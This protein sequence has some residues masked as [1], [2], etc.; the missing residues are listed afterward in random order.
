V[1]TKPTASRLGSH[2]ADAKTE[3]VRE[4]GHHHVRAT[5]SDRAPVSEPVDG[6]RPS[7]VPCGTPSVTGQIPL[8]DVTDPTGGTGIAAEPV[9][10]LVYLGRAR[11]RGEGVRVASWA[12]TVEAAGGRAVPIP[13]MIDHRP[14]LGF[15][16]RSL[17]DVAAGR[18]VPESMA[19]STR[20]VCERL[21]R[22]EPDLVVCMT[23]RAYHP[24]LLDGPWTTVL[25]HVD[26]LAVSYEGRSKIARSLPRRAT[27][28][29]LA[30][31]ARRFER[32]SATTAVRQVAAGWS[33]AA[34]LGAL[35]L[36]IGVT[37]RDPRPEPAGSDAVDVCFVGTLSYPPNVE[38]LRALAASWPHVRRMRPSVS[39][40]VAGAN[41]VPEVHALAEANGWEIAAN[42]GDVADIY[43]RARVAVSP[44]RTA[45]G[46]QIK[47]LEAASHGVPQIVS[48]R[49]LAGLAP[50]FPALT[51]DSPDGLAV[52]ILDLL[53]SPELRKS[54]AA[55]AS[56]EITRQYVPEAW[57]DAIHLLLSSHA[58]R[59]VGP[60]LPEVSRPW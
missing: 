52:K 51:A 46:I 8:G 60:P 49:A 19:W 58:P 29:A 20:S 40:L 21:R 34:S 3:D 7:S 27:Y 36:P 50:G 47:V 30:A 33:D 43:H 37:A 38:A 32:S 6:R 55:A 41:P 31:T 25:D 26:H 57:V 9:V 35:W 13:L 54:L 15:A 14:R 45:T 28:R 23:S 4:A 39:A 42:F 59:Q 44:L 12:R 24:A 10:A 22:L 11:A 1:P 2:S 53:A 16:P 56:S 17:G 18:A 5:R 48:S